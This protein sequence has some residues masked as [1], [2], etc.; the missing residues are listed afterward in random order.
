MTV[1]TV[2]HGH[3]AEKPTSQSPCLDRVNRTL[4][5]FLDSQEDSFTGSPLLHRIFRVTRDFVLT[6]GKRL[7]PLFCY[8]GWRGAGGQDTDDAIIV[9]S[10]L[11]IFHAFALI[12]DDIIDE[13]PT[14]RGR[15]TVHRALAAL[16]ARSRWNGDTDHFGESLGILCGDL[17]LVWSDELLRTCG[18][19][20]D[21]V[22]E[23]QPLLHQMR[24]ELVVGQYLDV[25]GQAAG[26]SLADALMINRYK[27]AKYTVQRPLQ[28]G[29]TLAGAESGLLAAY[30]A[31]GIPLG[32]AFQL[33]DDLLSVFGDPTVT[34]KTSLDDLRTGKPTALIALAR[35]HAT[36]AQ[37][38][39]IAALHGNPDLDEGGAAELRELLHETRA[40]TVTEDM[41]TSRREQALVALQDAPIA[42]EARQALTDLTIAA[43]HRDH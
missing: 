27:T 26:S 2:H 1:P 29:G 14:R 39:R 42:A 8:W 32:E 25:L 38:R 12:H 22:Q 7:R 17:C 41:I 43:T 9:A 20:S 35:G 31:F 37:H 16:H 40:V 5:K 6:G 3:L 24:T 11:E 21:Q 18:L 4:A 13:S 33:R 36:P 23:A 15:P 34:G 30:T 10:S 28:I 19:P